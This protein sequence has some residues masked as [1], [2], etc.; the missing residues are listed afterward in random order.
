M[1]AQRQPQLPTARTALCVQRVQPNDVPLHVAKLSWQHRAV[2]SPGSLHQDRPRPHSTAATA[3]QRRSTALHHEL[4]QIPALRVTKA[5]T[6]SGDAALRGE[7]GG[8]TQCTSRS[9]CITA[10]HT[11]CPCSPR[12]RHSIWANTGSQSPLL[13]PAPPQCPT[14]FPCHPKCSTLWGW[15]L[16][17]MVGAPGPCS[18]AGSPWGPLR[19][20]HPCVLPTLSHVPVAAMPEPCITAAPVPGAQPSLSALFLAVPGLGTRSRGR[21]EWY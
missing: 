21:G 3:Q 19:G 15:L 10:P 2:P 14:M 5:T 11:G 12:L 17:P 18:T 9:S 6:R 8:C 16:M 13:P 1:P 7:D 4:R 20:M